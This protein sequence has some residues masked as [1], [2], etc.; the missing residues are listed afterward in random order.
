MN[1]VNQRMKDLIETLN[2]DFDNSNRTYSFEEEGYI[3]F[4]TEAFDSYMT[5]G[6]ATIPPLNR[7]NDLDYL[8]YTSDLGAALI[9][10]LKCNW[11]FTGTD[12]DYVNNPQ[13]VRFTTFRRGCYNLVITESYSGYKLMERAND[14]CKSLRLSRKED[15]VKVFDSICGERL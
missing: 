4:E 8:V 10:A 7:G 12:Q 1:S 11:S 5:F 2:K 14:L 3:E 9:Y 13:T 15:R 6:S